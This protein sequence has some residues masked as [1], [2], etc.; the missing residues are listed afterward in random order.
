MHLRPW[1][2][3]ST[4]VRSMRAKHRHESI[5]QLGP[6][7]AAQLDIEAEVQ[8]LLAQFVVRGADQLGVRR[9]V[10]RVRRED[11]FFLGLQMFEH[12]A[13]EAPVTLHHVT[14]IVGVLAR[15]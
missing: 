5:E 14:R 2:H 12:G 15:S 13:L 4:L 8:Q 1:I 10:L 7:A 6:D 9:G 11:R 3:R